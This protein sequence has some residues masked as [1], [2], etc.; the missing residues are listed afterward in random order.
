MNLLLPET[1]VKDINNPLIFLAGP[2]K[3][4][5]MW[6]DSA[7]DIIYSADGDIYIAS[8]H[9][10]QGQ[11]KGDSMQSDQ[12]FQTQ[13]EWERYYLRQ[14][15]RNG[16]IM[17]WL[18]KEAEHSCDRVYAET[19]RRE[20]GE[21]TTRYQFEDGVRLAIGGEEGFSGFDNIRRNLA[22]DCPDLPIYST[23]EETCIEA[24]RL[25]RLK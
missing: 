15:A 16:A 1:Y 17:F 22:E 4:G 23:L 12:S 19:T 20:L 5:G 3:G 7:I 8:P 18:P 11:Y 6:Q 10:K 21:W 9:K 24:I 2:I 14:A 25:A 13:L